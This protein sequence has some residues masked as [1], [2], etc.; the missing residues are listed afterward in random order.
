M[1]VISIK[2]QNTTNLIVDS[3][4]V[5][6]DAKDLVLNG[7]NFLNPITEGRIGFSYALV[8]FLRVLHVFV[9]HYDF[10]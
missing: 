10:K 3:D 2:S 7:G 1:F 6:N 8:D 5:S 4:T 9:S